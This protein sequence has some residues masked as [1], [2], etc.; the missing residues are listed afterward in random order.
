MYIY[1]FEEATLVYLVNIY[2]LFLLIVCGSISLRKRDMEPHINNN[3]KK[4]DSFTKTY[5]CRSLASSR[6]FSFWVLP[7]LTQ[8]STVRSM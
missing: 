3:K 1:I 5:T 7:L 8:V 2:L 6:T 4:N